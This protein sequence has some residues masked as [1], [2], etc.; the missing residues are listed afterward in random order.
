MKKNLYIYFSIGIKGGS[1]EIKKNFFDIKNDKYNIIFTENL[2]KDENSIYIFIKKVDSKDIK[3]ILKLKKSNNF[4]IY[5]PIDNF[6]K[7]INNIKQYLRTLNKYGKYFDSIIFNSRYHKEIYENF[8]KLNKTNNFFLYHEYDERFKILDKSNNI[9]YIGNLKKSSFSEK[10]LKKYNIQY[11]ESKKNICS[12]KQVFTSIHID[13]ILPSNTYYHFHTST[14]L[15]TAMLFNSIFICNRVPVY[16]EI[17]GKEYPF[18]L[19]D[20]LSNLRKIINLAFD[21]FNNNKLY[22]S[23][24]NLVSHVKINLSPSFLRE[25]FLE[26]MK[27]II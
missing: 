21:T 10:I 14:K 1:G 9:Y 17:L 25:D 3:K 26:N 16:E 18:Y 11:V 24:L 15:S 23:Y 20:N 8:F 4:F 2:E 27:L 7:N 6:Y 5:N 12:K 13:Y 22:E 19:E